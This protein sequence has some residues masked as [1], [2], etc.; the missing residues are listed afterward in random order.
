MLTKKKIINLALIGTLLFPI[1][2]LALEKKETI[3]STLEANGKYS[4]STVQN[5]LSFIDGS[6]IED[7]TNLKNI[8][9]IGEET[10][11]IN[12][13][14][15]TWNA[16]NSDIYYKGETNQ[17]LP[18]ET[19][20]KYFLND[21]EKNAEEMINSKGKITIKIE[22]KNLDIQEVLING[23]K[24]KL[25]TPYVTT[26]GTLL[27]SSTNKN[28]SISNG[29]IVSTGSRNMLIGLSAP[30]LYESLNLEELKSLNEITISYETTKFE[31][32]NIYIVST[33][34]LLGEED[35]SIFQKMDELYNNVSEL[36]KN[37]NILEKGIL[38]LSNGIEPLLKGQKEL[39]SNLQN[40]KN[41]ISQLANGSKNLENGI[42]EI[43]ESL[44]KAKEDLQKNDN[45]SL[46]NIKTLKYQ[47][48]QTIK[49]LINKTNMTEETLKNI[50]ES[51]NL[52]NYQGTDETSLAIKNT[53]ELVTLLRTNNFALD[54][55]ITKTTEMINTLNTLLK[56]LENA[57]IKLENGSSTL[58][59]GINNLKVGIDKL[60]EGA[61][62]LNAGM[63]TLNTGAKALNTG[64]QNFNK[65]GISKLTNYA[66]TIK[67]Y[68]DKVEA[69]SNI[70]KNYQ[71]FSSNNA[72][73]T[74]F[75]SKVKSL[76]NTFKK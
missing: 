72:T 3:Y 16:S 67:N 7:E 55:T 76:K 66:Y 37:M 9:N 17:Q 38:E 63:N 46:E 30:G 27:N 29:K 60:Y 12:N 52:K 62:K 69:L 56:T 20:I 71:G 21:E 28:I 61:N 43:I 26:I 4:N 75:I 2:A 65:Q 49:N 48:E 58:S 42:K 15:L 31:T 54:N 5:H 19:N 45:T 50:Y 1:N 64:A 40:A 73:E 18:I 39:T 44:K 25:Y 53:Y 24:E 11:E 70:S 23:K 41:G 33:P 57:L 74:V 13:N 35:L 14:K 68:S 10:F 32:N 59:N 47:N 22:F 36:Q 8:L 6:K 51:N 34:K